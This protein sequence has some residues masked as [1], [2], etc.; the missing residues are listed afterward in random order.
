MK[1][2]R[3]L[4]CLIAL[5]VVSRESLATN[6]SGIWKKEC[7]DYYGIQIK[8]IDKG[9]Y[10]VSF[11]GLSGC[12]EPGEWSPNTKIEGD[13]KY[14]IF[15]PTDLGIKLKDKDEFYIYKKCTDDATWIIAEPETTKSYFAP[16]VIN[17]KPIGA[18]KTKGNHIKSKNNCLKKGGAWFEE[19]G[20]YAYCVLPYADAGKPCKNSKD[21]IGH[22]IMPLD[23]KMLDG[24][25]LKE[26]Y[27]ICQLNDSTDDCGRPHFENGEIIYFNCD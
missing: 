10:S 19:K 20:Y 7:S 23:R 13:S 3:L 18:E 16:G 9:L 2:T 27:G 4:I 12:F 24:T 25:S 5:L 15:S 22:C 6:Y 1:T 14:K 17:R 21:C 11:C 8:H 26:G